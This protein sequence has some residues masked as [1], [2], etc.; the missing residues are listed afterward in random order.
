MTQET[1]QQLPLSLSSSTPSYQKSDFFVSHCNKMAYE[2]IDS[3]PHWPDQT[4]LLNIFGP[5]GCGKTHL[6]HMIDPRKR[7]DIELTGETPF[8]SA[9]AFLFDH[10]QENGFEK[11]FVMEADEQG[12]Q[13]YTED[14]FHFI[15]QLKATAHSALI[16]SRTP[17]GQMDT[18]LP[19]LNSRL[20]AMAAQGI[21]TPDDGLIAEILMKQAADIQ[22][23]LPRHVADYI[24]TH[25][26]RS[27]AAIE[28]TVKQLNDMALSQ[29]KPATLAL[30]RQLIASQSSADRTDQ[31]FS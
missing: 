3:W 17:V 13:A 29:K 1:G 7:R 19:D 23:L 27:F 21:E 31:L 5:Q 30:A 15:N 28:Q 16:L 4:K 24:V 26:E 9:L 25:S 10:Q 20:R 14:C 11:C 22:L 2:W 12:L 8:A 18:G 6:S